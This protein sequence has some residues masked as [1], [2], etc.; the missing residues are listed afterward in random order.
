MYDEKDVEDIDTDGE[1]HIYDEWRYV[2]MSN[3]IAPPEKKEPKVKPYDPLETPLDRIIN[4]S[5]YDQ[6]Q[7][8]RL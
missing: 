1:D 5:R 6:Y 2:C 3:P 4:G 7:V 8:Y